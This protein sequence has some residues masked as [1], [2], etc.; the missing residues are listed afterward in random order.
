[1]A[2][3]HKK[4]GEILQRISQESRTLRKKAYKDYQAEV[5]AA[6]TNQ[7]EQGDKK[8]EIIA[9]AQ[10]IEVCA[11]MEDLN[12]GAAVPRSG[13]G[14]SYG[15]DVTNTCYGKGE[16][17]GDTRARPY[18]EPGQSASSGAVLRPNVETRSAEIT[19]TNR[20][21]TEGA[22][23]LIAGE[24]IR[25]TEEAY[26]RGGVI[27]D[28]RGGLIRA[29]V[30]KAI[31]VKAWFRGSPVGREGYRYFDGRDQ[32]EVLI[33]K[34][35]GLDDLVDCQLRDN[36]TK[37]LQLSN[38]FRMSIEDYYVLERQAMRSEVVNPRILE[39]RGSYPWFM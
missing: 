35:M 4:E 24:F 31:G 20:R 16:V 5:G 11:I 29:D 30:T 34:Q 15:P 27:T 19:V 26:V 14:G 32:E 22:M 36:E 3:A 17:K 23:C 28:Q 1:M 6:F 33:L 9:R 39:S 8:A 12:G 10:A 18:R 38:N 2:T 37:R 13:K 25:K 7:L 21:T